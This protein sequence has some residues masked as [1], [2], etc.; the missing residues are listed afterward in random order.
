M[1][2][3]L[4]SW[5]ILCKGASRNTVNLVLKAPHLIIQTTLTLIYLALKGAGFEVVEPSWKNIQIPLDI[6]TVYQRANLEPEIVRIIC[7]PRCFKQYDAHSTQKKCDWKKSPK[8]Q[9]CGT[10]LWS[11]RNTKEGHKRVPKCQYTTTSFWSWLQYFLSCP[12]IDQCLQ[13]T[14]HKTQNPNPDPQ[15]KMNDIYDS[16]FWESIKPGYLHTPYHLVFAFYVDWFNPFGNKAAGK[17]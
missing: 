11:Y 17:Y 15:K 3:I 14:F 10:E 2:C 16:P 8:A 9:R 1:C 7:C 12:Q 4:A 13:Q 5:L 6:R